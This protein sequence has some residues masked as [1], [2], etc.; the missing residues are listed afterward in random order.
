MRAG[1]SACWEVVELIAAAGPTQQFSA[2]RPRGDG[3]ASCEN[4]SAPWSGRLSPSAR[5]GYCILSHRRAAKRTSAIQR[6]PSLRWRTLS[7]S[8]PFTAA[9]TEQAGSGTA[10]ASPACAGIAAKL[11]CPAPPGAP[12]P[13]PSPAPRQA[14]TKA[15]SSFLL[16]NQTPRCKLCLFSSE[17]AVHGTRS[18]YHARLVRANT[19]HAPLQRVIRFVVV[20]EPT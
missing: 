2:M 7:R 4:R 20:P 16:A 11:M 8:V 9:K 6:H 17:R 13:G 15:R 14:E 12:D 18:L 1:R 10:S 19:L 5:C 3:E